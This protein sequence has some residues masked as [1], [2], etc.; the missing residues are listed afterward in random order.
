MTDNQSG[1]DETG[2]S[3]ALW[4]N[5]NPQMNWRSI[6]VP[7]CD[8]YAGQNAHEPRAKSE[9]GHPSLVRFMY[10]SITEEKDSPV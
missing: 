10:R 2:H 3:K 4:N 6:I 9:S 8:R 1:G 7:E 5:V